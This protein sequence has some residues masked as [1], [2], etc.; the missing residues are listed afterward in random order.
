MSAV[1]YMYSRGAEGRPSF[2]QKALYF[3]V[4]LGQKAR[5]LSKKL[6]N[7]GFSDFWKSR[8]RFDLYLPKIKKNSG[9]TAALQ[10]RTE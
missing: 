4:S 9:I 6:K 8:F 3:F 10:S 2:C 1:Y 7:A 5:A